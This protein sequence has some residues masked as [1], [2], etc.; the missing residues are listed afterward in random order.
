MADDQSRHMSWEREIDSGFRLEA[1]TSARLLRSEGPSAQLSGPAAQYP[2]NDAWLKLFVAS[3]RLVGWLVDVD[4]D[5]RRGGLVGYDA[6]ENVIGASSPNG[7]VQ[8]SQQESS[9]HH[10][11]SQGGVHST[12]QRSQSTNYV[13]LRIALK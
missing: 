3:S 4:V 1:V 13:P 5:E 2:C 12:W 10:D 9:Q 8:S 6:S 7:R 11:D